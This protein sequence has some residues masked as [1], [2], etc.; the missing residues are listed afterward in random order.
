VIRNSM[1]NRGATEVRRVSRGQQRESSWNA[2]QHAFGLRMLLQ[3]VLAVFREKTFA[4]ANAASPDIN[5]YIHPTDIVECMAKSLLERKFVLLFGHRQSG[6]TTIAHS[7]V[8]YLQN[9]SQNIQVPG[10][11]QTGFE[12]YYISFQSGIEFGS[13]PRF[14][15]SLC[16]T[17]MAKDNSRFKFE[18]ASRSASSAT[19]LSFFS[20]CPKSRQKPVILIIDEASMLYEIKDTPGGIVDQFIGTLRAIKDDVTGCCLHSIALVGTESV[21]DVLT[22]R[23]VKGRSIYSPFSEEGSYQSSRFSQNE[24]Q[25][26]LKQFVSVKKIELDVNEI[27][28]D[29][30]ELTSGHKGL[31]GICGNFIENT[32]LKCSRTVSFQDWNKNATK[33]RTFIW[34]KPT[35]DSI[36]RALTVLT[37]AQRNTLGNV[38]RYGYDVVQMNDE[39]KFLLAEGMCV[40]AGESFD[41]IIIQCG[42]PVLSSMMLSRICGPAFAIPE[43]PQE[44]NKLDID[45]LLRHTIENLSMQHISAKQTRNVTSTPSEYS[46]QA[47]F[48]TVIK[49]LLGS[50]YPDLLYRVLPEVKERHDNGNW[51]RR[52][53]ILICDTNLPRYG[54]EL[55]VAADQANFDKH[56]DNADEYGELHN[57]KMYLINLCTREDLTNYFG[58]PWIQERVMPVHVLYDELEGKA[59]LIYKHQTISILIN[60]VTWSVIFDDTPVNSL[61]W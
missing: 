4:T 16:A 51:R 39:I 59:S 55:V 17:L 30:Y 24:V 43:P 27:A 18:D 34:G 8:S 50:A 23:Q 3:C 22:S 6:K 25:D 40:R 36:M 33:L 2:L 58:K 60:S 5:F 56:M 1:V 48:V 9:I 14:W 49:N 20:K 44:T 35:Y 28:N 45:W 47:E 15:W 12:V 52:L 53:D 31:V 19:F 61:E 38:L 57:C 46:F 10:Y 42:A 11:E 26:L 37:P 13:T 54:F 29:I 41:A 32:L 7:T 21:R